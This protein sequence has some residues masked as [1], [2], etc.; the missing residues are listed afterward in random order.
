MV[1]IANLSY[2]LRIRLK[3]GEP[4]FGPGVM[5]LLQ[6][7]DDTGSLQTAAAQINMSYSK[8]WKIIK[9]AEKGLGF[10]LMTRRV[11]GVGGGSSELTE[12]GKDFMQRYSCFEREVYKTADD[13]FNKH[14]GDVLR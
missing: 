2:S 9:E 7:V 5:Q 4:F 14:F 3:K 8:A 13:L 10:P 6:R 11:G 1:V 12:Q